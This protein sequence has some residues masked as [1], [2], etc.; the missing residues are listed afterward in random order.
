M[1]FFF[2]LFLLGKKISLASRK[3]WTGKKRLHRENYNYGVEQLP[4]VLPK[5]LWLYWHD[6]IA[7]ASPVI[8]SAVQSWLTLNPGWDVRIL[9]DSSLDRYVTVHEP[10]APRRI[11]W[12]ADLIRLLLLQR[13]G[14]VWADASSFCIKPLDH[15]LPFLMQ[16]GIFVFPDTYPARLMSNWFIA[17]A[18]ENPLIVAWSEA[19]QAEYYSNKPIR[20]YYWVMHLFEFLVLRHSE[21]RKIWNFMPKISVKGPILLKRILTEPSYAEPLPESVDENAIP[22]LKVSSQTALQNKE[23]SDS[24]HSQRPF[25]IREMIKEAIRSEEHRGSH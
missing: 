7:N 23:F 17:A 22:V 2:S 12:R 19:M 8:Q 18:P 20:D 6:G 14:G 21:L 13:Y 3:T 16:S 5:I 25:C 10:S 4:K 11:Q 1:H 9:D 15:W 24:I